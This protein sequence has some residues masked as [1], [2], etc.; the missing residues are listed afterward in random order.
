[1]PCHAMQPCNTISHFD[2]MYGVLHSSWSVCLPEVV[3][4]LGTLS[5][6]VPVVIMDSNRIDYYHSTVFQPLTFSTWH[7]QQPQQDP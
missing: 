7:D 5:R 6:V 3:G 2:T 1:M 4:K